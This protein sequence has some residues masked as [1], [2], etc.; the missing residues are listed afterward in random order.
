MPIQLF[1]CRGTEKKLRLISHP[2]I[3]LLNEPNPNMSRVTL[4]KNAVT[5]KL[6]SGNL[7]FLKIGEEVPRELH[8]LRPDRVTVIPGNE[9]VMGIGSG[10]MKESTI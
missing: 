9:W 2:L 10:I 7:Y 4:I 5:Y 6:I 8:L 1:E 3:D